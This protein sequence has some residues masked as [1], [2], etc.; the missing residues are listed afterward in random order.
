MRKIISLTILVL[1]L[2][3]VG[4]SYW[5]YYN[6]KSEGT[7]AGILQKFSRKG[8]V[9]KTNEGELI[10]MG[11]GARAGGTNMGTDRFLFSVADESVADSLEHQCQGK[12]VQV[13]YVQYRRSLPW[14]GDNYNGQNKE[15]GQYIVDKIESVR[16]VAY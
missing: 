8:N 6:V 9:F 16:E 3:V 5:Y 13:H 15:N 14:R 4:W 2:V 12:F 11:F 10:M 7:R 1:L